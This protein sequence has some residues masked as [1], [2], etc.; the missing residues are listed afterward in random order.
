VRAA[1]PGYGPPVR[2][3]AATGDAVATP[4]EEG[5]GRT[6]GLALEGSGARCVAGDPARPGH[7]PAGTR[8]GGPWR[9]R[10]G[11]RTSADAELPDAGVCSVAVSA[12]DAPSPHDAGLRPAGIEPGGLMRS[13]D[14][15]RPVR[16]RDAHW[17]RPSGGGFP[18]PSARTVYAPAAGGGRLFAGLADGTI[19]ES[20]GVGGSWRAPRAPRRGP[21]RAARARVRA[22]TRVLALDV[23]TSSA[24]A[25]VHDGRGRPAGAG[26]QVRYTRTRGHSGRLAEY[27]PDELVEA[28]RLALDGARGEAGGALDAVAVSCFWHSLLALD[29]RGRP[30]TPVLGWRDTRSAGEAEELARRLDPDAVHA[31]TGCPLHASFWPAKLAW[32]RRR[33][34]EEFARAA[35]FVSF[36]DYLALR[37][38]GDGRT[39]LS[40]ASG[41][42]LLDVARGRWDGGLLH[43]LGVGEE[44]LPELS[45]EPVDGGAEPWF[46]ALGDGACSNVGAGCVFA[47]RAA[48]MVG[49]SG[50]YRVVAAGERV[51]RPGL[52]LLRL[53]A[54]RV[55]EGGSLSDGGNLWDWLGRTLREVDA[56]GLADEPADGH[57]LTFL[58]LLGGERSPGWNARATGAVTGLTFDTEPRHLV[59][60]AL[61]GVAFRF[62]EIAALLPEVRAVVATGG[63]LVRNEGWVR[64]LADVLGRPVSLSAVAEAS[65]RGA[66]VVALERLGCEP[67]EAPLAATFEPRPERTE[68]YLAAR[69]RQRRLYEAVT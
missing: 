48:L 40:M 7:V 68:A 41:T 26:A 23:G 56:G 10:D 57:G 5:G 13:W 21:A 54:E 27:D 1:A 67:E 22:V 20:A 11:G 58:A 34:P 14:D 44:R 50:A 25:L 52:F 69:E 2:L 63:A 30:L 8:G 62:A 3:Y 28:A 61:E 55:V 59:H 37:L 66:A 36:P 17:L 18:D 53:D 31:R 29:A 24:R 4:T 46:P 47:D 65:A 35:R 45:D 64:I 39:S 15:H 12:A 32:L 33:R 60:A 6:A 42:G 51:P 9:S 19:P 43:E 38:V 49:T 16:Q